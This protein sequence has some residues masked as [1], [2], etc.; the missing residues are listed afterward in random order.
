M[1]S[2]AEPFMS[3][4]R[5]DTVGLSAYVSGMLTMYLMYAEFIGMFVP[6]CW[7]LRFATSRFGLDGEWFMSDGWPVALH[8]VIHPILTA[9]IMKYTVVVQHDTVAC[10]SFAYGSITWYSTV[11]DWRNEQHRSVHSLWRCVEEQDLFGGLAFILKFPVK[12][13]I[14][15]HRSSCSRCKSCIIN[16]S[17]CGDVIDQ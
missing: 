17:L 9:I 16:K 1:K 6:F 3:G 5:L 14:H 10:W 8:Q 15:S 11:G 4:Y 12:C 2:P 7:N 13:L